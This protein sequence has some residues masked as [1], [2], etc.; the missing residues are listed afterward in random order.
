MLSVLS[1]ECDFVDLDGL[2]LALDILR[3]QEFLGLHDSGVS[4]SDYIGWSSVLLVLR[5]CCLR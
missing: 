4:A 5:R 2:R 1:E 3:Q